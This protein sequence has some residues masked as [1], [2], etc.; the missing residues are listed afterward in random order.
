M[1][2]MQNMHKYT[3]YIYVL[4]YLVSMFWH[5]WYAEQNMQK[6]TKYAKHVK[7]AQYIRNAPWNALHNNTLASFR[8]ICCAMDR[9]AAA[10]W[11][12]FPPCFLTQSLCPVSGPSH[13]FAA[14]VYTIPPPGYVI[15][16]MLQ[17]MILFSLHN[18]SSW[19][20]IWKFTKNFCVSCSSL[21]CF[22]IYKMCGI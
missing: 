12:V 16:G 2:N 4:T 3:K 10:P 14:R 1:Q 8:T 5:I 6:Y 13:K 20:C 17:A 7:Y 15:W 19:I 22:P 9:A 21:F 11:F 18:I